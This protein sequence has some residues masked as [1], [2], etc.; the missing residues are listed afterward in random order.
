MQL[1]MPKIPPRRVVAAP[2]H[3][4]TEP[5]HE[6]KPRLR[7]LCARVAGVRVNP[8]LES[9]H[10]GDPRENAHDPFEVRQAGAIGFGG[11]IELLEKFAAEQFHAHG[12]DLAEFNRSAAI[13]VQ[14]LVASRERMERVTG[15]VEDRFDIAL[16]PNGI[17]ENERHSRLGERGLVAARGLA[18]AI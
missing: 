10:R 8:M 4:P 17:H 9:I 13:R 12:G 3:I 11:R 2:V 6:R 16:K 1:S 15:F 14:V 18:L 7:P 5:I